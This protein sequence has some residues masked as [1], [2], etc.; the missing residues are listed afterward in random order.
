MLYRSS[1]AVPA[2]DFPAKLRKIQSMWKQINER[3]F[4]IANGITYNTILG[5]R[6]SQSEYACGWIIIIHLIPAPAS[7]DDETLLQHHI[8]SLGYL[9]N[10]THTLLFNSHKFIVAQI[11]LS[12][13]IF[14]THLILALNIAN[15]LMLC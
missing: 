14:Y 10:Q 1:W 11:L 12:R 13:W 4:H 15:H 7:V 5:V 2:S 6:K 8:H 3:S 9:L